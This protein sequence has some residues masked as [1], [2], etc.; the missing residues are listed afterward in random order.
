[1]AVE[2]VGSLPFVSVVLPT[3]NR[4]ATL[5]R[6]IASV[7]DQDHRALELIIVDDAS[8][9]EST[10]LLAGLG[11]PRVS[12]LRLAQN[13]GQ[14]HARNRGIEKAKA[15]LVAFQDSDDEWLPGKLSLQLKAMAEAGPDVGVVYGDMIRIWRDGRR[16]ALPAPE[17]R[18][19]AVFDDRPSL[20]Q[21]YGLGIQSCLIR[22]DLLL[23]IGGFNENL[24]CFEDLELFLRL[25]QCCDFIRLPQPLVHYHD[26]GGVSMAG[27]CERLARRYL[28]QQ[29]G[30]LLTSLDPG[31]LARE[32]LEIAPAVE[33]AGTAGP[34]ADGEV[35]PGGRA[36][37]FIRRI[38][39]KTLK[40]AW[41]GL[42]FW[43]LPQ[44]LRI[45]RAVLGRRA[46]SR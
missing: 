21:P 28:I 6:A 20:Y 41:W 24:R 16:E 37:A 45:R 33:A 3:F 17:I 11:D 38:V 43:R 40:L 46:G 13:R 5:A 9:D 29:Y 35:L 25:A 26:S 27:D 1:M 36:P 30:P 19:G 31:R 44:R 7:L 15:G 10:S 42:T 39:R 22:R 23:A 14:A 12:T 32:L 2:P 8:S 34:L 18:R 4:A